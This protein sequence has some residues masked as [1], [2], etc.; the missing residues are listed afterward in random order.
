MRFSILALPLLAVPSLALLGVDS[1]VSWANALVSSSGGEAQAS[2][3]GEVHAYDSWSYTDCGLATDLIQLK[4]FVVS[5]DPPQPGKNM[6]VTVEADVLDRIEEGAYVDVTVKLGLVKLLQKTFDV[7]EEAR[8]NNA[9]VQCPVEAGPYKVTQ[10][11]EL[12]REI[13]HAKFVVSVRGYSVDDEDL[14]CLNL[15]VDFM[16]GRS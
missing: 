9:S 11:V 8:N 10:T 1:A 3:G 14:V 12:P 13:P 4:S 16:K 2:K 7:C 15:F 5:P 6:T